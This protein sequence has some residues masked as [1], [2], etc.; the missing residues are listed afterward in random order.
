MGLDDVGC[1][2]Q[3]E[4]D[5]HWAMVAAT[6]WHKRDLGSLEQLLTPPPVRWG[7]VVYWAVIPVVVVALIA[8]NV[9]LQPF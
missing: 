4:I 3:R 7:R 1:D 8:T 5:E 2:E 6:P 9:V